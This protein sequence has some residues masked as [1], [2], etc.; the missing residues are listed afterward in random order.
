M[1]AEPDPRDE[2]RGGQGVVDPG[3]AIPHA[4]VDEAKHIVGGRAEVFECDGYWTFIA[5]RSERDGV[6]DAGL[7]ADARVL[8]A[9][10]SADEGEGVYCLATV[11]VD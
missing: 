4:R 7:D 2:A 1:R 9:V 8:V 6:G 3:R 10:A 11:D 5:G